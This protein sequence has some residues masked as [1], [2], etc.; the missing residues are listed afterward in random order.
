MLCA[1]QANLQ[2]SHT[3]RTSSRGKLVLSTLLNEYTF[4]PGWAHCLLHGQF[5][6][7]NCTTMGY[8]PIISK[9]FSFILILNSK[10]EV[11]LCTF[12]QGQATLKTEISSIYSMIYSSVEGKTECKLATWKTCVKEGPQLWPRL[13]FSLCQIWYLHQCTW[14]VT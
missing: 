6:Y 7:V 10:L 3:I 4:L 8:I 2:T 9:T 1:N 5:L 14:K 11:H 13:V 12:S